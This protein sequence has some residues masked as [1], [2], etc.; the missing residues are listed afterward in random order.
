MLSA[1]GPDVG[2]TVPPFAR[3][4]SFVHSVDTF[5]DMEEIHLAVWE[6]FMQNTAV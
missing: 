3:I 4:F 1:Q 2:Q 6:I 5:P